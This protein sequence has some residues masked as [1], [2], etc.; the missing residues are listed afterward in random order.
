MLQIGKRHLT[1]AKAYCIID[2][3]RREGIIPSRLFD[4]MYAVPCDARGE[5]PLATLCV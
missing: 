5:F 1:K 2:I 4:T 3:N